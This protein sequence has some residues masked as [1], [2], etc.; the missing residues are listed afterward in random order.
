[1]SNA[2]GLFAHPQR[3]TLLAFPLFTAKTQSQ[4]K[5]IIAGEVLYMGLQGS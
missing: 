3:N 5:A 4:V 1:M 2:M